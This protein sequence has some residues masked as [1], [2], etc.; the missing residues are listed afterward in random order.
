MRRSRACSSTPPSTAGTPRTPPGASTAPTRAR[1]YVHLDNSACNLASLNLLKF[2]RRGRHASTSRASATP[3]RSSSRPRRSWS[4]T[5][6]TPPSGIAETSR[7]VPPAR[8][9]LRQPR[10]AADGARPALRLEPR[11]GR[12]PPPSPSLMTGHAYA[13]SARIASRMGPFAGFADN[14]EHMLR[15]AAHAPWRRGPTSTRSG[16]RPTCSSPPSGAGTRPCAAAR[17]S[18]SATARPACWRRPAPSA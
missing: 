17:S 16:C 11:A 10:R 18:A 8:P 14:E 1:E 15:R 2:L 9:R 7:A 5:P 12:G 13:T 4:A 6:T 3:S